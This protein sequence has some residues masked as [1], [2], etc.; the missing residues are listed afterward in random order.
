MASTKEARGVKD[1]KAA[2]R[3]EAKRAKGGRQG[4]IDSWRMNNPDQAKLLDHIVDD[5][6]A[7]RKEGSLCPFRG[8]L[9]IVERE[10]SLEVTVNTLTKWIRS[11]Y[12][13]E[14]SV[15]Y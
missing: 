9:R 10:T 4:E 11:K 3:I 12:H 14:P 5:F 7:V 8:L 6:V 1:F 13:D 2:M 15:Q